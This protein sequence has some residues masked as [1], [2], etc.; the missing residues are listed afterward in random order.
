MKNGDFDPSVT[1]HLKDI[2]GYSSNKIVKAD[3][4]TGKNCT[5]QA[6]AFD[7]GKVMSFDKS[8]FQRLVHIIEGKAEVVIG[9]NST[10]MQQGDTILIPSGTNS[11]IEANHQFMMICVAIDE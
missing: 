7:F 4:V 5:I 2:L 11:S 10:F 1:F 9:N 8:T 6:F 3:I